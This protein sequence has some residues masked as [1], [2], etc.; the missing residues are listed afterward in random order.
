L[1]PLRKLDR[2]STPPLSLGPA[3]IAGG[4]VVAEAGGRGA[5]AGGVFLP[6]LALLP[7]PD[8]RGGAAAFL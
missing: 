5:A 6:R 4:L 1:Q 7:E 2:A 3:W 8:R